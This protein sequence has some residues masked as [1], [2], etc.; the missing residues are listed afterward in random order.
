M[1]IESV[2]ILIQRAQVLRGRNIGQSIA[3]LED[4]LSIAQQIDYK[5]GIALVIRDK[6]ACAFVQKHYKRALTGYSEALQFL[7]TSM[8]KTAS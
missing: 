4:A 2:D 6:A 5:K 8:I 7:R 3:L 1:G